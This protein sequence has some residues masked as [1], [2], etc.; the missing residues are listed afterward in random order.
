MPKIEEYRKKAVEFEARSAYAKDPEIKASYAE[1]ARSY[2]T[3]AGHMK[4]AETK[5]RSAESKN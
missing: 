1:L 4:D 3:L 2:R 5:S